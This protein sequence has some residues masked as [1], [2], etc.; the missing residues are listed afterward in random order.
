VRPAVKALA[1]LTPFTAREMIL[2][3]PVLSTLRTSNP[4]L[5]LDSLERFLVRLSW[6]VVEQPRIKEI[7][8]KPLLVWDGNVIAGDV[9][10]ILH[11]P[12]TEERHL[13]RPFVA[14]RT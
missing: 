9:Q 14:A 5:P 3:S 1:P 6:L 12:A 8:V 11:D 2:R 4:N 13:P 7:T 10:I